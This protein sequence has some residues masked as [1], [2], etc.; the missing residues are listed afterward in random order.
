MRLT[1]MAAI[2]ASPR[3]GDVRTRK[4]MSTRTRKHPWLFQTPSRQPQLQRDMRPD[5]HRGNLRFGGKSHAVR[6]LVRRL[7]R[8][9]PARMHA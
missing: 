4:G 2:S 5:L 1:L 9:A 6:L 3:L 8:N 7:H